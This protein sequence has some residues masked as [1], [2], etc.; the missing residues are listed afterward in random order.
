[1]GLV[2]SVEF[3][4]QRKVT[5]SGDQ[6][7]QDLSGRECVEQDLDGCAAPTN[8]PGAVGYALPVKVDA[9]PSVP[10]QVTASNPEPVVSLPERCRQMREDSARLQDAVAELR[11][12]VADLQRLPE[13]ARAM[14]EAAI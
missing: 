10:A 12:A 11:R 9:V 2:I 7:Q 4:K 14:C 1:M 13:L 8:G 5:V 3:S 6:R